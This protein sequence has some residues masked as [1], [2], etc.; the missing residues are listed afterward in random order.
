MLKDTYLLEDSCGY[1]I[2]M[3]NQ[4][5]YGYFKEGLDREGINVVEAWI[6]LQILNGLK[7]VSAF[8]EA[9]K[10]DMALIQR[11]CN[12]LVKEKILT[13]TVDVS[14]RRV[15]FL[16]LTDKGKNLIS[17]VVGH[18]KT[19]NRKALFGLKKEERDELKRLLFK[20]YAEI[21]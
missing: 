5:M 12:R 14:D 6:L 2:F 20:V 15:K 13:R 1:L 19:T 21:M 17:R 8:K 16:A 18:S 4:W 11:S 3:L 9:L 7:T 10:V